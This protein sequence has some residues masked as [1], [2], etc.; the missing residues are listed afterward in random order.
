M[1]FHLFTIFST[2]EA[3]APE[4]SIGT[5]FFF[6]N[7]VSWRTSLSTASSSGCPLVY[8]DTAGLT[9]GQALGP[10]FPGRRVPGEEEEEDLELGA[11]L[12]VISILR[13]RQTLLPLLSSLGCDVTSL[14]GVSEATWQLLRTYVSPWPRSS[15]KPRVYC[16]GSKGLSTPLSGAVG[17]TPASHRTYRGLSLHKPLKAETGADFCTRLPVQ[18]VTI[19]HRFP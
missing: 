14:S 11:V 1:L 4:N 13:R 7:P 6:W 12:A 15:N 3:T 10:Y 19:A 16:V 8:N 9:Y 5:F 17:S 18:K 2:E